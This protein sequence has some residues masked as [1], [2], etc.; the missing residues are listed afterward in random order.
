MNKTREREKEYGKAKKTR[1]LHSA[2]QFWIVARK[3]YTEAEEEEEEEEK[4]GSKTNTF[5]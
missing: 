3:I 4:T 2:N 1:V 5:E